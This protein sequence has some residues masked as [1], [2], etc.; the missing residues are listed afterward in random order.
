MSRLLHLVLVLALAAGCATP[1]I[2]APFAGLRNLVPAAA[3]SAPARLFIVHGMTE[4][5]I[6]Y[7]DKLV[8]TLA[9]EMA[10]ET[11]P[12]TDQAMMVPGSIGEAG[13]PA[14]INLR[15][16]RL[17]SGTSERLRVMAVT[18]SPLTTSIKRAR[19]AVDDA[20]D[21]VPVNGYIKRHIVSDGLGDAVLYVGT[22]QI[23]MRNG[24]VM[25]LC[26]FL[27]GRFEQGQ[28]TAAPTRTPIGFISH[29]L[30]SMMLF[31]A[32][33]Q[34]RDQGAA[35]AM[36]AALAQTRLFFMFANQLPLLELSTVRPASA[37][38]P[39][40]AAA[41]VGGR[42]DRFLRDAARSRAPSG[43][44]APSATPAAKAASTL[45]VVAFTDPS[46][47]LS[48]RLQDTD[49][50]PGVVLSNVTYPVATRWLGLFAD[51]VQA[52]GG[53]ESDPVVIDLVTCGS[54]RC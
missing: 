12:P 1:Q 25:A 39:M 52:H 13:K 3:D 49:V 15:V 31:D 36:E 35:A 48:Y 23:V 4:H 41:A 14:S 38:A 45:H 33:E 10:L 54:G 2:S 22:Y 9:K 50:H 20:A 11:D 42:L 46:D 7:A 40:P 21:R 19:F 26:A 17:R 37:A 51:P 30:G 5:S 32:I 44:V 16:F 18:W 29:S 53:Y 8:S 6:D 34:L 43:A 47:L 24:L 28:C 27:D